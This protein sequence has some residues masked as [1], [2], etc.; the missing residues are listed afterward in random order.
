MSAAGRIPIISMAPRWCGP[1]FESL[2]W[3][4]LL[5]WCDAA[6]WART[7]LHVPRLTADGPLHRAL[8]DVARVRGGEVEVVHR[9][10]RALLDSDL[11][12]AEYWDAAVRAKKR[13]NCG[14]SRIV[15]LKRARCAFGAGE[16]ARRLGR[17][18]M[19]SLNWKH[20]AG[21]GA[22]DRRSR[23]TATRRRGFARS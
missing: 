1:G 13:R 7:L 2:F 22:P 21:K 17:G 8:V 9:E 12:P 16:R 11:S 10:E 6:P 15:S 18:S 23:A 20:A 3:S 4:I 19:P 14:G 5:G